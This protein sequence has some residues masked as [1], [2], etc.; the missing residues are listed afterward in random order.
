MHGGKG[1]RQLCEN[2]TQAAPYGGALFLACSGGSALLLLLLLAMHRPA[3]P[4][5]S[6]SHRQAGVA[7]QDA[8]RVLL[9]G[10]REGAERRLTGLLAVGGANGLLDVCKELLQRH[11]VEALLGRRLILGRRCID[12]VV[13][14]S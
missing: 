13:K 6:C 12:K 10:P 8:P 4:A 11:L 3:L 2:L 14:V 5:P 1:A 7:C 9:K